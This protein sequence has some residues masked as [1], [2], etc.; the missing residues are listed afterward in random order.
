MGYFNNF[1]IWKLISK[2]DK[3]L[4]GFY[5][6]FFRKA[7]NWGHDQGWKIRGFF[8]IEKFSSN[9][10]CMHDFFTEEKCEKK[11][12]KKGAK[13]FMKGWKCYKSPFKIKSNTISFSLFYLE[14]EISVLSLTKLLLINLSKKKIN[15]NLKKPS[16][17][18]LVGVPYYFYGDLFIV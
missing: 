2:L 18:L 9:W 7:E 1:K 10:S 17:G 15:K 5:D 6:T 4:D 14:S 3:L 8:F 16:Q 11:W 12:L 13:F